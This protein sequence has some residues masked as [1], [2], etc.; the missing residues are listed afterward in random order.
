MPD[1][2]MVY[3]VAAGALRSIHFS[4][5]VSNH[6]MML[7]VVTMAKTTQDPIGIHPISGVII[8]VM[9]IPILKN[10][11]KQIIMTSAV[12]TANPSKLFGRIRASLL[13]I[14]T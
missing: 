4:T 11:S 6:H 10:I 13:L 1:L 14:G 3:F 9:N 12:K 8:R 7:V 2:E 5:H